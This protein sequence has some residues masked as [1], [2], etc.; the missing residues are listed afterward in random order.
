MLYTQA[1]TY[2]S[3]LYSGTIIE[4]IA[5]STSLFAKIMYTLII[6]KRINVN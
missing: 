3:A 6:S 5:I 1:W 4:I 2:L